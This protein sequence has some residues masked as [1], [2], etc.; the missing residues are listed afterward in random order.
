MPP[1]AVGLPASGAASRSGEEGASDL[2]WRVDL[3]VAALVGPAGWRSGRSAR[4]AAADPAALVASYV[5]LLTVGASMGFPLAA[6]L[7]HRN[8][9]GIGSQ[10]AALGALISAG[11]VALADLPVRSVLP[12]HPLLLASLRL[13]LAVT[14]IC[15]WL[16]AMD[17]RHVWM[18]LPLGIAA[19]TELTL[20]ARSIGVAV[21]PLRWWR[22]FIWSS[23]HAGA[24][25]GLMLIAAVSSGSGARL[26]VLTVYLSFVGAATVAALA[27]SAFL[28]IDLAFAAGADDVRREVMADEHRRRSHWL[29]DEVCSD[30][31]FVRLKLE[32]GAAS[33]DDAIGELDDLDHRLRLRQV[34]ELLDAG[35]ARLNEI[36]QPYVRRAIRA[37]LDFT[38]VPALEDAG[39]T[40]DAA[41][42]YL[43]GRC[44]AGL[45]DNARAAGA[46]RVA[47]HLG[48][49]PPRSDIVL[50]VTDDAGGFDFGSVMRSGLDVLQ[51]DL[52]RIGGSLTA[53]RVD[54]GSRMTVI[55]PIGSA[56]THDPSNRLPAGIDVVRSSTAAPVVSAP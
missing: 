44:V 19:G 49:R 7:L 52:A 48:E 31:R 24:A 37:G 20:T 39:R 42:G 47:I 27:A 2:A 4:S 5:I 12:S 10:L 33:I 22:R 55:L 38:H 34:D 45:I 13:G 14:A 9:V 16:V 40:V 36:M 26:F 8:D 21:T 15:L 30:V 50:H 35:S 43:F 1:G 53:E 56:G 32:T 46:T 3:A 23:T 51:H 6:S 25:V 54:G 41:T 18:L 28:R 11:L 17:G 29:H